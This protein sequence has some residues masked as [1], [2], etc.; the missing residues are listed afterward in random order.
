MQILKRRIGACLLA[1]LPLAAADAPPHIYSA[2]H[3]GTLLDVRTGHGISDAMLLI[4]DGKVHEAGAASRVRLLHSET[5]LDLTH[6][7]CLPGLIDVHDH[8]TA[9]P[10]DTGY[11]GLGVSVPRETVK[12]VKNARI[13]LERGFTT[14][15]NVGASGYSDVALRDG[16]NAG[17]VPGPGNNRRPLR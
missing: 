4:E 13:T 17:E 15:R 2:V 9:D 3:C 7:T 10:T 16:I 11:Q 5:A 1:A 14:V 12:G 6:A 8:L